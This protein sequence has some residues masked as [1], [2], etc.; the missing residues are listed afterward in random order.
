MVKLNGGDPFTKFRPDAKPVPGASPTVSFVMA[1]PQ[2]GL[3]SN[4]KDADGN[5][6]SA[7]K[8][9]L[10]KNDKYGLGKKDYAKAWN[11]LGAS[12]TVWTLTLGTHDA[13][14][15]A[16]NTSLNEALLTA[17]YAV[18]KDGKVYP[19]E[20]VAYLDGA[21]DKE[22]NVSTN[23]L[24]FRGLESET[25]LYPAATD[26]LNRMG[27]YNADGSQN[28]ETA[29]S[30]L[31]NLYAASF[32]EDNIDRAFTAY[33]K[34]NVAHDCY[35]PL[36]SKQY[37]NVRFHRPI[38]VAA[39]V[40]DWNDRNLADNTI[41]I[42]QLVEIVDWNRFPV[43]A[44]GSSNIK[45]RNTEF[46]IEQ[47]KYENV[48]AGVNSVKQQNLG[49]PY[50]FYGIQELAVRY[51]EIRSDMPKSM[52]IR[53][54][55]NIYNPKEIEDNSVKISQIPALFSVREAPAGY[56]TITLLHAQP[57]KGSNIV[58][59]D[60][61]HAYNHSNYN[62]A[63][64]GNTSYGKLYFNNDGSDTQLFHIFVPI[65]VKYNWG[66]IAWDYKFGE[67]AKEDG[68]NGANKLD[69]DY[70]QTIWAVIVVNGTH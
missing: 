11:V 23:M 70:T 39:K 38:N 2:D 52:D 56:R 54:N 1:Y 19:A 6:V 16:G 40:F 43:V 48:F 5:G 67:Q 59:F 4:H 26:L 20:E 18:G 63:S 15:T 10:A 12:G 41:D 32:L 50:E 35:D 13:P 17:I 33:I 37:F 51:D 42:R 7:G 64:P 14:A 31:T 29:S 60:T 25:A 57:Y 61:P 55:I 45:E 58:S 28:F 3:N 27:A 8:I 69:K 30:E 9:S 21:F 44:Y 36:I 68:G 49:M 47:P 22:L 62:A 24:H 53:R 65:A 34:I 46:G 66:N